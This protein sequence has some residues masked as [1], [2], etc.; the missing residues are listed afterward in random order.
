MKK[1][2]QAQELYQIAEQLTFQPHRIS[3]DP[4][5]RYDEPLDRE[6]PFFIRLFHFHAVGGNER[7]AELSGIYVNR[8]KMAVYMMCGLCAAMTGLWRTPAHRDR[9]AMVRK[10]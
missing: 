9:P 8:I 5:G 6:F 4:T 10:L 3:I 7:A 2:R 1:Q